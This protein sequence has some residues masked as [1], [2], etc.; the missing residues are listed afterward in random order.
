[1]TTIAF[2]TGIIIYMMYR[3]AKKK[4]GKAAREGVEAVEFEEQFEETYGVSWDSWVSVKRDVLGD[5]EPLVAC[6]T[7]VF[8]DMYRTVQKKGV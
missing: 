8:A 5:G 3:F 6:I 4:R 7:G 2:V 1:M